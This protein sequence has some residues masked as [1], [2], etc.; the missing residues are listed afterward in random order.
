MKPFQ[1]ESFT[2]AVYFLILFILVLFYF[3]RVLSCRSV[4]IERDLSAFFIPPKFLWVNLLKSGIFPFWNPHQFCGIPLLAALQ[5]GVLYPPHVFYL[6]LPF[7]IVWNWLIIL[8]FLLAAVA[9]YLFLVHMKS[10]E[11]GA[12]V[13]ALIF[14][15]SGYLL[16][17]HNLLP[18]L[19]AVAWFPLVLLFFLKHFETRQMRY[20]ALASLF[21]LMQ[22]LS[23]APEIFMM[24][25]LALFI[26][27]L[28][29]PSFIG[30]HVGFYIRMR[31]FITILSLFLLL[32]AVQLLPFYE[33][34]DQ[35]IRQSGLTYFESSV[36]SMAWRDFIQFFVP[37]PF[38]NT[39]ND[40]KY[41]QNQSWLKTIYLGIVPFCL[42]TFYFLTA[43]RRRWP[44]A[45]LMVISLIFALGGNTPIYKLLYRIPPFS[46]VRYPVKFLF[47]FIFIVSVTSGLGLD[48]LRQGVA[49]R[50][51]RIH[52]AIHVF[53]YVG[54]LFALVF[55][56]MTLFRESVVKLFDSIGFKPDAYNVISVNIHDI[57]RFCFFAFLFCIL[58]LVYRRITRKGI[59]MVFMVIILGLDLFLANYGFYSSLPW[60]IYVRPH[61]FVS[62][63][64]KRGK[65]DRYFVT[66]KTRST[67]DRFPKD[68][69]SMSSSYAPLS[70]LYTV[71]GAEVLKLGHYD[72][73][74]SL[75]K[76]APSLEQAK[77]YF[78]IAGV[79]YL[80][81]ITELDNDDFSLLGSVTVDD[82][83]VYLYEYNSY[84]GHFLLFSRIRGVSDERSMMQ[85]IADRSI[86]LRQE[87]IVLGGVSQLEALPT[88]PGKVEVVSYEPNNVVLNCK[89]TQDALLYASDT[90]YPGWK[91]YV[92]GKQ[93]EIMRANLAFR[94]VKVPPGEHTIIF[95]YVPVSFYAGLL[96]TA[97][98]F[99]LFGLLIVRGRK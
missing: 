67:Y 73:F 64:I 91:A 52:G 93:E 47:L 62:E 98:G 46:S 15:L 90:F 44:F 97:I 82:K 88:I 31:S 33:L 16:S 85:T 28:F 4:F 79:R 63:I 69:A 11:E 24:S 6:F 29:L 37:D 42:S 48:K 10:S 19:F 12:F 56:Y 43:G 72:T 92:D 51:R 83:P 50:S 70:G 8:H 80:V 65:T 68:K 40:Q 99:V 75:L 57:R 36:W 18:H 66:P 95:R 76:T 30:E 26:V 23:G 38:G 53:F 9:V 87:L 13:G 20:A 1:K 2:R 55:A 78:D 54:F 60:E 96:V 77:R 49:E 74:M 5:P 34:K 14:M 25:V 61:E 59:V 71:E 3:D 27:T 39:M 84:P 94:A 17:V 7:P 58:L 32:S 41:W 21:L 89:T 81:T 22:F 45:L 86:D 35:S